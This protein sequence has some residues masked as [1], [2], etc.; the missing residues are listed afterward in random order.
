MQSPEQLLQGLS[1][2][3]QQLLWDGEGLPVGCI[4]FDAPTANTTVMPLGM[5]TRGI[6]ILRKDL[7][8]DG[9]SSAIAAAW[10][11]PCWTS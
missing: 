9:G 4:A 10:Q 2:T 7:L 6:S 5:P 11:R 3:L 1:V 8:V